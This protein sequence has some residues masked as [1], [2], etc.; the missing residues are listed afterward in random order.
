MQAV[1]GV[2]DTTMLLMDLGVVEEEAAAL[3]RITLLGLVLLILEAGVAV[4]AVDLE[5][6][7][8]VPAEAA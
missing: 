1:A 3:L 7:A 6:G 2:V 5:M 8:V 4:Q